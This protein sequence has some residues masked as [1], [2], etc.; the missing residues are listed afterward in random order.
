LRLN[1]ILSVAMLSALTLTANP[2]WAE[3]WEFL[4]K[5]PQGNMYLDRDSVAKSGDLT[6]FWV[7]RVYFKPQESK[8]SKMKFQEQWVYQELNCGK[9]T[10]SLKHALFKDAK[11]KAVG[12]YANL[13]EGPKPIKPAGFFAQEAKLLCKPGLKTAQQPQAKPDKKPEQKA[14]HKT[15]QK[16][17]KKAEAGK[18]KP[19]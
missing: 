6:Y 2:G 5:H 9:N 17:E 11:G 16:P 7:R 13:K 19:H 10:M 8:I 14:E 4:G 1:G 3:K 15:D 18:P 12:G